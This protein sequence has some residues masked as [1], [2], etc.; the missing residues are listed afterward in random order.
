MPSSS[1]YLTVSETAEVL[2][3][4]ASMVHV[5]DRRRLLESHY[6]DG[7]KAG[8]RFVAD[9]VYALAELRAEHKGDFMRRLPQIAL[10]AA[11]TS[12]RVEKRLN[13]L[14]EFLGLN[15]VVLSVEPGDVI[16][17]HRSVEA[18]PRRPRLEDEAEILAWAKKILAI[19]EEYLDLIKMSTGDPYPWKPY[20]ELGRVLSAIAKGRTKSFIEHARANLRNVAY[21]YE[22]S[23]RGPREAEKM[24]PNERY[25][26]RLM[27]R[28]LP[29]A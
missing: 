29:N 20:L 4:S 14:L 28:L 5:F 8:K 24:F 22:R 9:D 17:L 25:S 3:V 6:P 27:R 16:E 7:R 15:D 13:E 26:G 23:Y 2:G 11:V 10:K 21:F 18:L 1:L 19:N 12:R